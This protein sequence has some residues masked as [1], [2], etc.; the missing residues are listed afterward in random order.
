MS[1]LRHLLEVGPVSASLG[2]THLTPDGVAHS[3]WGCC[4]LYS[5]HLF[6]C[7]SLPKAPSQTQP[8]GLTRY[9]ETPHHSPADM[10]S[11]TSAEQQA[12]GTFAVVRN[13]L[14]RHCA[15]II[16]IGLGDMISAVDTLVAFAGESWDG[17]FQQAGMS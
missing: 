14:R 3:C 5:V 8:E 16:V 9:P 12:G 13:Q 2:A 1:L 10:K 7:Q 6:M 15:C 17:G 11:T 4:L